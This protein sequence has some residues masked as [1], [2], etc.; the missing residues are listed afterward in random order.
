MGAEWNEASAIW[1]VSLRD[2]TTG[3]EYIHEAKIFISAVGGY[4]NPKFPSLPGLES[5]EGPV[6][7]TA[8][9]DK[10]YDLHGLN[11]AIIGNG[12]LYPPK[13]RLSPIWL[14]FTGS[15]SQVVPAI[16]GKVKSLKQFIRVSLGSHPLYTV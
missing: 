5:F 8:Q 6:V 3:E 1:Q 12:C 4:T 10:D 9:W 15:A 2:L 11:V 16:A 7:H 13:F 14:T